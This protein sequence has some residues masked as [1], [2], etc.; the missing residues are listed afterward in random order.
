M[1]KVLHVVRAVHVRI[2]VS[3][4]A[5]RA[6][7]AQPYEIYTSSGQ[8]KIANC[9]LGEEK[10]E[11]EYTVQLSDCTLSLMTEISAVESLKL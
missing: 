6:R 3:T 5:S 1:R 10:T 9:V 7:R 11:V 4:C 2:P 8:L